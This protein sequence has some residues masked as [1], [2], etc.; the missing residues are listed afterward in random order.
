MLLGGRKIVY[1]ALL[2]FALLVSG[3]SSASAQSNTTA[4]D[5]LKSAY[6]LASKE[7]SYD[8]NEARTANSAMQATQMD[9]EANNWLLVKQ[10]DL[11]LII[12]N[13]CAVPS[14]PVF[15]D[16]YALPAAKCGLTELSR[17]QHPPECNMATWARDRH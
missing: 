11:T 13:K 14:E 16:E 6:E 4:C 9:L 10:M 2:I 5:Q 17:Q 7:A 12:Q 1:A 8:L 3:A 15:A